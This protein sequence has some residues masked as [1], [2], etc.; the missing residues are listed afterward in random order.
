MQI[1][2]GPV[3]ILLDRGLSVLGRLG[4]EEKRMMIG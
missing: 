3:H 4:S 2:I 1:G